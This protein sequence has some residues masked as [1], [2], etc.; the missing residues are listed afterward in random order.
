M[1]LFVRHT[2]ESVYSIKAYAYRQLLKACI[3]FIT[4]IKYYNLYFI[5]GNCLIWRRAF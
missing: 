3:L 1:F 2:V 4:I 5:T